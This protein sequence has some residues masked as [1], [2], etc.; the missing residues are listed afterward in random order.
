MLVNPIA[1]VW[2]PR[3]FLNQHAVDLEVVFVEM[4]RINCLFV[5]LLDVCGQVEL[6]EELGAN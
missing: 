2:E 4:L 1:L 3:A 6:D 5:T